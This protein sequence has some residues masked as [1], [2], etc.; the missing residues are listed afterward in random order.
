MGKTFAE[1][2]LAHR[3]G[4]PSVEVG[5]IVTVKPDH[6]L[7]H[8]NTSAIVGK[9]EFLIFLM[10][11]SNEVNRF[12]KNWL[13]LAFATRTYQSLYSITLFLLLYY[14]FFCIW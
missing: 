6:L 1:K 9:V 12:P 7:T 10:R 8:D 14:L 5:Q 2:L 13:S 11:I 4:V 3:A